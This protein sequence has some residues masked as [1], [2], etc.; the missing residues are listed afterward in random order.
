MDSAAPH[1]DR[2]P[3][4][5]EGPSG[6]RR[7]TITITSRSL[8]LA[9]LIGLAVLVV[10]FLVIKAQGP[11]VLL[12][13]SIILGEAIRPLV[14]RLKRYHIPGPVAVLLIYLVALVIAGVLL[15]LLIT[16]A[17]PDTTAS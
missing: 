11:I 8:W 12:V 3:A 15:W 7:L 17:V 5:S 4:T 10:L 13:L 14:V 6:R 9:A 2:A 16:P 1:P